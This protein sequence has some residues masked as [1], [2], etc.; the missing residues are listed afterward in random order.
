MPTGDL[1]LKRALNQLVVEESAAV[2]L[3]RSGRHEAIQTL[4]S[5]MM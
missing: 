3:A 4:L 1:S 2:A 5:F